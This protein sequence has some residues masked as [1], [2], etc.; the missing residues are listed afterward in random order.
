[1][2]C[3]L[4]CCVFAA[5]TIQFVLR[6]QRKKRTSLYQCY[7]SGKCCN[8]THGERKREWKSEEKVYTNLD[9][10]ISHDAMDIIRSTCTYDVRSVPFGILL[11][12]HDIEHLLNGR[13]SERTQTYYTW[14]NEILLN[15]SMSTIDVVIIQ[16]SVQF[17]SRWLAVESVRW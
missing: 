2:N 15:E 17:N 4:L 13:A 9:E 8:K 10:S 6:Q 1:M 12:I 14:G 3:V 11:A 5:E 7:S 16:S